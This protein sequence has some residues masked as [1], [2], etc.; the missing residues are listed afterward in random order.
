[1]PIDSKTVRLFQ[2]LG[3]SLGVEVTIAFPALF[4]DSLGPQ[5]LRVAP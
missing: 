3:D 1:M 5:P 4:P 2:A